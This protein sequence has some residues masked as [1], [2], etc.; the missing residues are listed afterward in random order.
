MSSCQSRA[1]LAINLL[2]LHNATHIQTVFQ[3]KKHQLADQITFTFHQCNL[4]YCVQI[5]ENIASA[6]KYE[7]L[8]VLCFQLSTVGIRL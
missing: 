2:W 4:L 1:T 6:F 8:W 5:K 3:E 7:S